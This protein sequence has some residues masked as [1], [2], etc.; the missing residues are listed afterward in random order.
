MGRPEN[1]R[2][3]WRLYV[4]WTTI[5]KRWAFSVRRTYYIWVYRLLLEFNL[6]LQGHFR[7]H[8]RSTT[9]YW[10]GSVHVLRSYVR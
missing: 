8:T 6:Q 9:D 3:W 5:P 7:V 4:A 2:R 1:D 10:R